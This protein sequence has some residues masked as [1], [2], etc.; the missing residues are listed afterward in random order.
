[1]S[2]ID[3]SIKPKLIEQKI[4]D[5]VMKVQE[6]TKPFKLNFNIWTNIYP[7]LKTHM[8]SISLISGIVLLL[9][10]RYYDVQERKK[11]RKQIHKYNEPVL[12]DDDDDDDYDNNDS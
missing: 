3:G 7:I 12:D 10:Y 5:K 6:E 2:F 11:N 4:F 8:L 1:M 9:L